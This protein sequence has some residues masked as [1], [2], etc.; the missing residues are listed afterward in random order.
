[1]ESVKQ[2]EMESVATALRGAMRKE[3]LKEIGNCGPL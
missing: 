3:A 2:N 1:M